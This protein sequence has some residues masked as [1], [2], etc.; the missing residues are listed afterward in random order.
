MLE[1]D[2]SLKILSCNINGVAN[3]MQRGFFDWLAWEAPDI[4]CIQEI[5]ETSLPAGVI[6]WAAGVGYDVAA[7]FSR[8]GGTA[9]L[10]RHGF[11]RI[12]QADGVL[13][14]R[15]Q[16]TIARVQGLNI[17]SVYVTLRNTEPE[18]GAFDGHFKALRAQGPSIICG[19]F[20]II[21]RPGH[22]SAIKYGPS[23]I[24]CALDERQWLLRLLETWSD[25][26]P[27]CYTERPLYTFWVRHRKDQL[28]HEN[29]GTRLDYI[30]ATPDLAS[31]LVPGSGRLFRSLYHGQRIT[32]HAPISATFDYDSRGLTNAAKTTA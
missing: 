30:L 6:S 24:G 31:R 19:D 9:I 8:N 23:A 15:G 25:A 28:F 7:S 1:M 11:Q 3:A 22:D 20:N 26:L 27:Q 14:S 13:E 29:R 18:R 5:N 10:S 21:A 4:A 32:D 16:I 12:V 2:Q 17:A